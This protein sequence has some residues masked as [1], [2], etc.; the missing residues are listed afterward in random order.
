MK[1]APASSPW[2]QVIDL[3]PP[4]SPLALFQLG[5]GES[6]AI[7]LARRNPDSDILV[8]DRIARRSASMLG[9]P[10]I[11]TVGLVGIAARR[12]TIESFDDAVQKVRSAGLFVTDELVEAVRFRVNRTVK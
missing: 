2:L 12:G 7:E 6:E 9:L 3:D 11:G 10:V 8:D 4:L 1:N 5:R